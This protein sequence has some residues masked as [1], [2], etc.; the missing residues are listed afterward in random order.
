[1]EEWCRSALSDPSM[2]RSRED[3]E[4]LLEFVTEHGEELP[5]TLS[6]YS[7][8]VKALERCS[9]S[10][11]APDLAR[12]LRR[13]YY[14]D[15]QLEVLG[16]RVAEGEPVVSE[17]ARKWLW[18]LYP[19]L[20]RWKDVRDGEGRL[21]DVSHALVALDVYS[22]DK[23]LPVAGR[24]RGR[25]KAYLFTYGGD[26]VTQVFSFFGMKEAGGWNRADHRGN[27]LGRRVVWRYAADEKAAL[28]DLMLEAA[29]SPRG[30]ARWLVF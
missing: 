9:P 28:S 11:G 7:A 15:E 13:L 23:P 19:V 24:V 3:A 18:R 21:M 10:S 2:V 30:L 26:Y 27:T 1:M 4:R 25:L 8:V 6:G 14:S 22:H 5:P 16:V 17:E 20:K 29:G 12:A